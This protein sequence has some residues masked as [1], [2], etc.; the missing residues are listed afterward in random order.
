[1]KTEKK[2]QGLELEP[3]VKKT[4]KKPAFLASPIYMGLGQGEEKKHKKR[5]TKFE[6]GSLFSS[7][8]LGRLTL[9]LQ[10]CIFICLPNKT[11]L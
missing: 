11:E 1:M 6:P 8:L 10:G 5:G 7:C 3:Q 9:M 2:V 4:K